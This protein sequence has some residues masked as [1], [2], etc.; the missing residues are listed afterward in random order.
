MFILVESSAA[1]KQD[2]EEE[3]EAK[4]TETLQTCIRSYML[5]RFFSYKGGW[6]SMP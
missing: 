4:G 6:G 5:T 2:V 3:D 1:Q